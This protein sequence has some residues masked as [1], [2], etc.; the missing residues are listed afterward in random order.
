MGQIHQIHGKLSLLIC[1]Y[2]PTCK[3]TNIFFVESAPL[4]ELSAFS[5]KFL[6]YSTNNLR[7]FYRDSLSIQSCMLVRCWMRL[8]DCSQISEISL[9]RWSR[10]FRIYPVNDKLY[11]SVPPCLIHL[12]SCRGLQ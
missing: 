5:Y 6:P 4:L 10:F 3:Y 1:Q 9:S 7:L 11:C 12:R 8:I 2:C